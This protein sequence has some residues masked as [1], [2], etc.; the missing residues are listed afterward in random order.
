MEIK[1]TLD[2]FEGEEAVF[3]SEDKK[4]IIWPKNKLPGSAKEGSAITFYLM[5]NIEKTEDD[6]KLAK[7]ILNEILNP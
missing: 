3:I 4:T 6:K 2:R 5:N 7:N 1:L